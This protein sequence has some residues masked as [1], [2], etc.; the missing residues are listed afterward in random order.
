MAN[1]LLYLHR[2]H[3]IHRDIKPENIL[4]GIHGELKM[5]DFGWSVHAPSGRR[6]TQCGTLDYLPP[7]MVDPRKCDKPYDQ[8]V[9]IWSLGVL[10]YE[11]LVGR[12]P[13]EDTPVMT[14]RRIAKGDM[15][16]PSFVSPEAK[17]L[18]KKLVVLSTT[19]ISLGELA[20][21]V[22]AIPR[23]YSIY[24]QELGLS[25]PIHKRV[26]SL[27]VHLN[28]DD[29]DISEVPTEE[30]DILYEWTDHEDTNDEHPGEES[31]EKPEKT[32][33]NSLIT[34]GECGSSMNTQYRV[35]LVQFKDLKALAWRGLNRY[36]DFESIKDC[37]STLGH[38][39]SSLT[40]DLVNWDRAMKIWADGFRR[41]STQDIPNNFFAQNV[42]NISL[43][44]NGVHF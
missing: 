37:F 18:I 17:D 22:E 8:K 28:G 36:S 15:T 30:D 19:E 41:Q 35:D 32:G 1:A 5:S 16:V 10:L 2:K 24:T 25:I 20:T 44:D 13:F 29:R 40:L 26:V 23:K 4:V 6:H 31:P 33:I 14:Q 43:G 38:Q 34:D 12:A 21:T 27:C 9:D 11:F 39:L 42:L 3:V 7:E